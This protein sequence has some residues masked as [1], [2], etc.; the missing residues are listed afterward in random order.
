MKR[1]AKLN[2]V[3]AAAVSTFGD[4]FDIASVE[5]IA[6]NVYTVYMRHKESGRRIET[7]DAYSFRPDGTAEMIVLSFE[8]RDKRIM[9]R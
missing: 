8:E 1:E 3:M 5:L 2:A 7:S 4:A 9:Y 6:A